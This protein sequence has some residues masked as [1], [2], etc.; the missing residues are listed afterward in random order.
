MPD[1]FDRYINL[2]PDTNL[3]N[4]LADS[5]ETLRGLDMNLL[6]AIGTQ[7]Y[8]PDK[9]SVNDILQHITDTERVFC[10]RVLRFARKDNT[11][12]AGY[13]ENQFA[14]YAQAGKR[15]LIDILD[16]LSIVRMGT[17]ALFK[18][19]DEEAL[20]QKG[21][22]WKYEMS[23]LAMGFTLVGHQMHH[24]NVMQTKY[25]PLAETKA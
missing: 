11:A 15:E 18:S 14:L 4:A 21:I 2:V 19:F 12:T 24:F 3:S 1:Y 17:I 13:D 7:T 5:L 23:V 22:C 9:W 10:Y 6:K 20:L 16:E 25:Y 8:A